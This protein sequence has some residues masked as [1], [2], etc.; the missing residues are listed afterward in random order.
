MRAPLQGARIA[1]KKRYASLTYQISDRAVARVIDAAGGVAR[2][3]PYVRNGY[4]QLSIFSKAVSLGHL[5]ALKFLPPPSTPG[6]IL[7]RKDRNS[8]N[9][10]AANLEWT[11]EAEVHGQVWELRDGQAPKRHKSMQAA[12]LAVGRAPR[13]I[14]AAIQHNTRCAGALWTKVDPTGGG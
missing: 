3:Y 8:F 4:Y 11:T 14:R 5:V 7:H 6:L 10:A 9:D 13:S 12:A 1:A 2:L